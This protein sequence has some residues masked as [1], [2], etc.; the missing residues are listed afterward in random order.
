[1]WLMTWLI[2]QFGGLCGRSTRL[3]TLAMAPHVDFLTNESLSRCNKKLRVKI[4]LPFRALF[5]LL[6]VL[7]CYNVPV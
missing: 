3:A 4:F 1:M 5:W 2:K 6:D 7:L